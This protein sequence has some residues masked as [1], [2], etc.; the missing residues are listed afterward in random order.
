MVTVP[1][2]KQGETMKASM[3]RQI[4]ACTDSFHLTPKC[5]CII[6]ISKT[7][8]LKHAKNFSLKPEDKVSGDFYFYCIITKKLDL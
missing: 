3:S 7:I 8:H 1:Q 2:E 4:K 6:T 5:M